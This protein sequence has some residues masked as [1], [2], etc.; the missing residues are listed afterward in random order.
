[1]NLYENVDN[2]LPITIYNFSLFDG[3][4]QRLDIVKN[5]TSTI[6]TI[7]INIDKKNLLDKLINENKDIMDIIAKNEELL[8][9]FTYRPN[10]P[11]L[12]ANLFFRYN[13]TNDTS[14]Y[15]F[16]DNWMNVFI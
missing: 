1:M 7:H 12:M 4:D 14:D 9:Q 10:V 3:T 11:N 15:I 13:D 5:E 8:E 16:S 2:E 6:E